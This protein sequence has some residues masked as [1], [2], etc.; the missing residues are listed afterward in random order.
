MTAVALVKDAAIR[1]NRVGWAMHGTPDYVEGDVL[2]VEVAPDAW[3][4]AA[5]TLDDHAAAYGR[6]IV[7]VQKVQRKDRRAL[8]GKMGPKS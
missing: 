2:A 5:R 1:I 8:Y 3:N 4:E 6:E 7:E